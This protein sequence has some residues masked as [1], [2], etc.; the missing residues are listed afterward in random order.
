MEREGER[1]REPLE[2][3]VR[4]PLERAV[5][6]DGQHLGQS[7]EEPSERAVRESR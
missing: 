2:R 7:H 3:I 6:G 5:E 1:E 4:E